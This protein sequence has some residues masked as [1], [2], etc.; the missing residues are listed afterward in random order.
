VRTRLDICV[1]VLIRIYALSGSFRTTCNYDIKAQQ[2]VMILLCFT[3]EHD[4]SYIHD[5]SRF[6][7]NKS[8]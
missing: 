1:F 3:N 5:K 4:F 7:R 2:V 6:I 8:Y